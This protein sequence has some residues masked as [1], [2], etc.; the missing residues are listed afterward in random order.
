MA[1]IVAR[2]ASIPDRE[3]RSDLRVTAGSVTLFTLQ[4]R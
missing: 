1:R 2:V 3:F 4:L